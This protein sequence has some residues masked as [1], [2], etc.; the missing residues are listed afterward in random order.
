[1]QLE[2]STIS[3]SKEIKTVIYIQ[4][5]EPIVDG[6]NNKRKIVTFSLCS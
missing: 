4:N 5:R 3:L 2:E 6:I 1:M